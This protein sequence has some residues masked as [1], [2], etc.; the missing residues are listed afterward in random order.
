MIIFKNLIVFNSTTGKP[1]YYRMITD[2]DWAPS[3]RLGFAGESKAKRHQRWAK[4]TSRQGLYAIKKYSFISV[5]DF[6]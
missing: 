1:S 2:V 6:F 5:I 4:V 3:L